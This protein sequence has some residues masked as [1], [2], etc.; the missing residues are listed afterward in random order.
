VAIS[1]PAVVV[2]VYAIFITYLILYY[3]SLLRGYGNVTTA[4]RT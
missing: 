1:A 2:T 4:A 3:L